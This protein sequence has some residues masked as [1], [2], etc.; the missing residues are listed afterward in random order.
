MAKEKKAFKDTLFGK[1]VGKAGSIIPD[2]IG[3]ATKVMTGNVGGAIDEVLGHL[4]KSNDPKAKELITQLTLERDKILLEFARVDLAETEAI[5]GDIQDARA[6]RKDSDWM[7]N[8][9]TI[10][11]LILCAFIV[12]AITFIDIPEKNENL[13]I[14]LVGIVEGAIFLKIFTFFFGSS[15]GSKDKTKLFKK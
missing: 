2:V 13:F 5:L 1:I 9:V 3:V 10:F 7:F 4:G 6:N 12:Y 8:L 14:H 15:K 11:G